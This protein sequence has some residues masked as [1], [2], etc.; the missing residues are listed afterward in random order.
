MLDSNTDVQI[1]AYF[2]ADLALPADAIDCGPWG[3]HGVDDWRRGFLTWERDVAAISVTVAGEQNH[4]GEV[5]RWLHVSGD[6]EC[7]ARERQQLIATL[8]TAGELFDSL[9]APKRR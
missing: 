8:A 9:M 1:L 5:T 2:F 4:H 7:T 6:G 3:W